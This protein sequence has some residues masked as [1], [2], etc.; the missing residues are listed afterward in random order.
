MDG[1]RKKRRSI[2]LIIVIGVQS[3]SRVRLCD[4]VD[5]SAPGLPVLHYLPELAQ[6]RVRWVDDAI[7]SS[8]P[9]LPLSPHA[10]N[11]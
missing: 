4:P 1:K 2:S 11:L 5:C 6:T 3:L 10:L 8:H 7:Q 9:L